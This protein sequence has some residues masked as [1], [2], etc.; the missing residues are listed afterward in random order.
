VPG[1]SQAKS[2]QPLTRT[3]AR[4]PVPNVPPR[5]ATRSQTHVNHEVDRITAAARSARDVAT[6]RDSAR[7]RAPLQP[8][9]RP[10]AVPPNPATPRNHPA[11]QTPSLR[12]LLA[13]R[14]R[15]PRHEVDRVTPSVGRPPSHVPEAAHST[16]RVNPST[17]G[18]PVNA[19]LHSNPSV[20]RFAPPPSA[21][22]RSAAVRIRPTSPPPTRR[23]PHTSPTVPHFS[24]PSPPSR[25]LPGPR[26][27]ASNPPHV[28]RGV[29][30]NSRHASS[31]HSQPS[32]TFRAPTAA[33][34]RAGLPGVSH[35]PARPSGFGRSAA[36]HA[37]GRSRSP[38]RSFRRPEKPSESSR[39]AT[40]RALGHGRH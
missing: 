23:S 21:S 31:S 11:T 4:R 33:R 36:G 20:R 40:G 5:E 17:P 8:T 37:P 13:S 22:S 34:P 38:A 7:A 15:A 2:R 16:P 25:T 30:G 39:S 12:D 19:L 24:R 29:F 14:A 18:R 32:M 27:P 35:S 10:G 26:R 9:P 28:T 3:P 1:P 6:T